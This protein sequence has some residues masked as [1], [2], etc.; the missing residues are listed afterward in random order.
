MKIS[1]VSLAWNK[2]DLTREFLER[3][4]KYTDIPFQLVFT[5]NGSEEPISALVKE[6]FP[7]A[8]LIVKKKNVGCPATRNEAMAR[9]SGDIVFWLDN[10]T[11]VDSGWYQPFL[12]KLSENP[13]TGLVGVDGRR[14]ANPFNPEN[15]W[16]FPEDFIPDFNVDWLVGYAVAFRK[17]AYRAIPDWGLMVN[18]DDTDL[19]LGIKANGWRAKMLDVPVALTHLVS[20][21]GAPIM[22]TKEEETALFGRWWQYWKPDKK[23]FCNYG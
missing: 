17:E 7:Q 22:P 18:L 10:D 20:Q 13:K 9:V 1:I 5:D 19:G 21:T 8:D 12:R 4:K 6:V 11:Y 15:P 16:S 14:V 2:L 23:F 3:L